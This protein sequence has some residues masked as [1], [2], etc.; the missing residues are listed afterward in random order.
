MKISYPKVLILGETFRLNGGGGITLINLFK[1]WDPACVAVVTEKIN[2][3]S[4]QTGC[5][6]FYQLGNMEI[7]IP[8]PFNFINKIQTSGDFHVKEPSNTN[9]PSLSSNSSKNSLRKLKFFLEIAYYKILIL[10][11]LY[12]SSYRIVVSDKLLKWIEEYS[13]DIIYA[14]PFKFCDMIFARELKEKTGIPLAIHI[15]D[16]SVNILNKPNLLYAFW[17]NKIRNA[18]E[19]LVERTDICLSI[20]ESMSEEYLKR[21]NRSFIPFRNPVEISSWEPFVKK[22][23]TLNDEVNVVY[24]GRLAVPNINSLFTFCQVIDEL[25]TIG[26]RINLNIYSIDTNASFLAKI[27]NFRTVHIHKAVKFAQIPALIT[28]FDFAFLPIDFTLKG[29]KYAQFS[30]STKTSEYMISGVPILL[31]APENIALT[32]YARKNKCMFIV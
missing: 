19:H 22:N 3:T 13:P 8:F 7:R 2:E 23:W 20:S 16:D 27:N 17:K 24:T 10:L 25:N 21:Y 11:G 28:Q 1:D 9:L 5:D 6:K 4:F 31:F 32:E 14:Q 26:Y 29:I 18:F 15:M 12:N 30:V